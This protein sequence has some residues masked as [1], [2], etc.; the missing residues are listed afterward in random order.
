MGLHCSTVE[1]RTVSKRV[2]S[3]VWP[4]G[5][6]F[7]V[8]RSEEVRWKFSFLWWIHSTEGT[9][10]LWP[11]RAASMLW[12]AGTWTHS[13]LPTLTQPS[14]RPWKAMTR[15]TTCGGLCALLFRLLWHDQSLIVHLCSERNLCLRF[16]SSLPLTD[17][18]FTMSLSHDLPLVSSL[19][20]C[21]YVL[22]SIQ[23]T[24]EK[25]LLQYNTKHGNTGRRLI[26]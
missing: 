19:G 17:V 3:T 4:I 24:G 21:L 22:G 15:G 9:S 20:D 14:I 25:L 16:V 6:F 8:R 1:G 2:Y 23:G 18:Q 12:E 13:S 5:R 7:S 10:A 26:C 11:V